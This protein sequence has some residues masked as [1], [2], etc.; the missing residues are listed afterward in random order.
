MSGEPSARGKVS[1]EVEDVG[2]RRAAPAVD[3]LVGVADRGHRVAAPGRRVGPGEERAEQQ[4]L[5]DRGV[6]VLVEQHDPEPLRA[7][8]RPTSG[9]S[10]A[11]RAASAI[12]SEKSISPSSRLE[13]A[14]VLDEPQQLGALG[15]SCVSTFSRSA[16]ARSARRAR[17]SNA[18]RSRASKR[19]H[20]VGRHEVLAHRGVEREQ[21]A[22]D[23]RGAVGEQLHA[24][25]AC[26]ADRAAGQLVAGGVGDHPGV[27]L[28]ADPQPVLGEQARRRRR[29]RSRRS[30]RAAPRRSG[31]DARAAGPRASQRARGRRRRE[32]AGGLGGEGRGRAPGRAGPA[33]SRRGRRPGRPSAWS[34][35]SRRR[36]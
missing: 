23:V 13:P 11:S 10:R 4:R 27:G 26:R 3:R 16:L 18:A 21:V 30:A 34:C 12:W 28:V 7:R 9:C 36:R 33:R 22:D 8:R 14:V 6:L 5:G 31:G 29:C 25:G 19:A 35:R 32:L 20:V 15:R 17:A 1:A 2:D 24:G